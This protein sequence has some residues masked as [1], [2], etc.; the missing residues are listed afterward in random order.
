MA[1]AE[2]IAEAD[3]PTITAALKQWRL[4]RLG[5]LRRTEEGHIPKDI[6]LGANCRLGEKSRVSETALQRRLHAGHEG[7]W[8][9]PRPLGSPSRSRDKAALPSQRGV[10]RVDLQQKWDRRKQPVSTVAPSPC[11]P[12]TALAAPNVGLASVCCR[13]VQPQERAHHQAVQ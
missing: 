7:F 9:G 3:L 11:T 12:V 1:N 8:N 5:H 13:S 2:V 10:Q 4:R 6:F